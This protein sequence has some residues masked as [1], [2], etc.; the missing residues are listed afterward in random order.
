MNIISLGAGVQSTTILLMAAHGELGPK[1]DYAIFADTGWEPK[2]VYDHL[3][4]LKEESARFGIQVIETAKG[5]IRTDLLES[6][7]NH[8]RSAAMPFYV[9]HNGEQ[10]IIPRQCTGDYKIAAINKKGS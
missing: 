2:A 7:I 5:N 1:P 9:Y 4:W 10:G 3:K 6:S 8:S